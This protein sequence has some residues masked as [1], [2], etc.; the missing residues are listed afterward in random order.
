MEQAAATHPKPP[1]VM[2]VHKIEL[3]QPSGCLKLAPTISLGEINAAK[4]A[5][6]TARL[7][8]RTFM[9]VLRDKQICTKISIINY[10]FY[11]REECGIRVVTKTMRF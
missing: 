3:I 10:S 9:G 1:P 7:K 8:I 6:A 11:P 4:R 5:S 2:N